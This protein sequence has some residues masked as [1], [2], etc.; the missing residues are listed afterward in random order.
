MPISTYNSMKKDI[1]KVMIGAMIMAMVMA[2]II[3]DIKDSKKDCTT[4][5]S[6]DNR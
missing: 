4:L 5:I 1:A 2:M 3:I 6:K